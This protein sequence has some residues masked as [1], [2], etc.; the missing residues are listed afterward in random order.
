MPSPLQQAEAAVKQM[1]Q[2]SNDIDDNL[3]GIKEFRKKT[4]KMID[5]FI[6]RTK[7]KPC[8]KKH[9]EFILKGLAIIDARIKTVEKM[10]GFA[11]GAWV[12]AEKALHAM[13][14]A[15]RLQKD[16]AEL[17]KQ[18][19]GV[20]RMLKIAKGSREKINDEWGELLDL[21]ESTAYLI[22]AADKLCGD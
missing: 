2:I 18:L 13:Y 19:D 5:A 12:L 22:E 10:Q 9:Q 14:E 8:Y 7:G 15:A 20:L 17:R 4:K 11:D 6:A 3:K 21:D 1:E 16:D